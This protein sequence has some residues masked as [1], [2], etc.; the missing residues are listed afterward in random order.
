MLTS[1]GTSTTR[2]M[3]MTSLIAIV[4]RSHVIPLLQV[5]P[6]LAVAETKSSWRGKAS[7]TCTALATAG[8]WLVMTRV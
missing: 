1:D 2:V 6:S 8:P 4:F 3:V 5:E 7:T